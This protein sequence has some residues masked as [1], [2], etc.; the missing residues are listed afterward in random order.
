M[1]RTSIAAAV[2]AL[3]SAPLAAQQQSPAFTPVQQPGAFQNPSGAQPATTPPQVQPGTSP[4]QPGSSP[5]Q[6]PATPPPVSTTPG[7][8]PGPAPTTTT[9]GGTTASPGTTTP[10]TLSGGGGAGVTE[11]ADFAML[12]VNHDGALSRAE[13]SRDPDLG[14]RFR[15]MDGD[16]DGSVSDD[17]FEAAVTFRGRQGF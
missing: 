11:D 2:L 8:V 4:V 15:S 10:G 1:K 16:R 13:L 17:E 14:P 5:V 3:A 6:V 12:D 9:P 7:T